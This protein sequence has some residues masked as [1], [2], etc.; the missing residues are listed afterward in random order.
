MLLPHTHLLTYHLLP[1]LT[2]YFPPSGSVFPRPQP[3]D[4]Q[5]IK[6]EWSRTPSESFRRR[7]HWLQAYRLLCV[8]VFG[9]IHKPTWNRK[10]ELVL[11]V[12]RKARGLSWIPNRP[13]P[14]KSERIVLSKMA[15]SSPCFQS[16]NF[17]IRF[18]QETVT[19]LLVLYPC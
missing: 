2:P 15:L 8:C 19:C 3:P 16:I 12:W 6:W 9:L 11:R 18:Q 1:A 14:H 4:H 5:R 17:T 7:M 13:Y 10:S